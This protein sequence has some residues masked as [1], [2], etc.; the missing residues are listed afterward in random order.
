MHLRDRG[1]I[2]GIHKKG[3]SDMR[4]HIS[5]HS[6]TNTH[7]HARAHWH[8]HTESLHQLEEKQTVISLL[9]FFCPWHTPSG[10]HITQ[11]F[12]Q[13]SFYVAHILQISL[14]S[15]IVWH[16]QLLSHIQFVLAES[17]CPTAVPQQPTTVP[18]SPS[19]TIPLTNCKLLYEL[20]KLWP[21]SV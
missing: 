9:T 4:K 8:T 7:F 21:L 6:N 11:S 3:H 1:W 13:S 5:I 18:P 12:R 2:P 15:N 14:I 16:H 20:G 10:K 19:L 17:A